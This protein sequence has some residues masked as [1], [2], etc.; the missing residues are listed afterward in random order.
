MD[1]QSKRMRRQAYTAVIIAAIIFVTVVIGLVI[2]GAK[3]INV[4]SVKTLR[5]EYAQ[6]IK[7]RETLKC[8]AEWTP[9]DA[10]DF[11]D[12]GVLPNPK[13]LTQTFAMQQGAEKFYLDRYFDGEKYLSFYA[14][15][16]EVYTWSAMEKLWSSGE[17]YH[18]EFDLPTAPSVKMTRAEFEKEYPAFFDELDQ[19]IRDYPAGVDINCDIGGTFGY[20]QPNS[21]KEWK[22]LED[23]K[24]EEKENE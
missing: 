11:L 22:S 7:N 9:D 19:M 3:S 18:E 5:S 21:I 20:S 23:I 10:Y 2:M 15:G 17:L 24:P 6:K 4:T 12:A 16:D 13:R 14:N 1:N 8:T